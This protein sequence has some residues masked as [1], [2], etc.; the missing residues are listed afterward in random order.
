[1]KSHLDRIFVIDLEAT[2][3]RNG[4]QGEKPNEII[5]IGICQLTV[6]TMTIEKPMS[7]VVKP[8]WTEVSEFCTELTG[9]T[10]SS[11]DQGADIVEAISTVQNIYGFRNRDVWFSCGQY[12]RQKLASYGGGSIGALYG[13]TGAENPF[14][15]MQ[16]FNVKPL[17]AFKHRLRKEMGMQRMLEHIGET[18]DG[19]HHS[20]VDDAVNIAKLVKHIL[21]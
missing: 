8:R 9:W 17:F 19:R 1:M 12:D 3:W 20:G 13:I 10:Q 6:E 21:T 5:E 15:K 18:L 7:I 2:C 14:T 4:E 11:V 16:H